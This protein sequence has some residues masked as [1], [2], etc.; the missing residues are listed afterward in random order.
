MLRDRLL[1]GV[2]DDSIQRRLLAEDGLTFETAL[3]KAQAIE[4]SNKDMAD[5]HREK[6]NQVS[7]TVFKV[8]TEERS[9]LKGAGMCYRCGGTNH[10]SKDCKFAKENCYKCGK[11]VHV[12]RMCRMKPQESASNKGKKTMTWEKGKHSKRAN[13]LQEEE[14]CEEVFTMYSIQRAQSP[15]PHFTQVL[16]VNEYPV[17][18]EVDTGCSVTVF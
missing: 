10:M 17:E 5:L 15:V 6:G 16:L 8:D 13:Y 2:N 4:T 3:K 18:F 9:N 1:C 11:F 12:K 7:T 14:L